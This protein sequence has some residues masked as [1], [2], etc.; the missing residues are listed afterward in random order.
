MKNKFYS[1]IDFLSNELHF[2][3]YLTYML[4][5]LFAFEICK[6]YNMPFIKIEVITYIILSIA[7]MNTWEIKA[8]SYKKKKD[9]NENE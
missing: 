9:V 5:L 4:M 8:R 1:F 7:F 6:Y 3:E 2:F